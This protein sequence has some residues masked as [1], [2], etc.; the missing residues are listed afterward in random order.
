MLFDEKSRFLELLI[1]GTPFGH[2][3]MEVG[4]SPN[5]IRKAMNEDKDFAQ[6]VR[7]ARKLLDE[8]VERKL[9]EKALA[10]NLDAQKHWLKHRSPEEWGETTIMTKA[11]NDPR[12]VGP[13]QIAQATAIALRELFSSPDMIRVALDM[14]RPNEILDAEIVEDSDDDR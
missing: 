13:V 11:S 9:L 1:E 3:A 2:A 8:K 6:E 4:F 7:D 5:A 14:F 10:G 12:Q